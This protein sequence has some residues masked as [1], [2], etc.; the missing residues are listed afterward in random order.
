[1][2]AGRPKKDL[3]EQDIID[4]YEYLKE[5]DFLRV[6]EKKCLLMISQFGFKNLNSEQLK[7]AR[8]TQYLMN[9]GI[10]NFNLLHEIQLREKH[11]STEK[12]I[13]E[14]AEK[15]DIDSYFLMHDLL[16]ATRKNIDAKHS[17][18][19]V[20]YKVTAQSK[21]KSPK[22]IADRKKYFLGD[23]LLKWMNS[24]YNELNDDQV[25][26]VLKNMMENE[27]IGMIVRKQWT[28]KQQNIEWMHQRI[29][30]IQKITH[31]VDTAKI[32][33]RNPFKSS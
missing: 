14:L 15:S 12:K 33:S 7:L 19:K 26:D 20:T 25:L 11:N 22:K 4:L 10:K 27:R 9:R 24:K 21:E 23:L 1:M 28:D 13:L 29:T 5:L 31:Q 18:N 8:E 2:M 32:D 6:K 30:E 16:D 17:M 3:S